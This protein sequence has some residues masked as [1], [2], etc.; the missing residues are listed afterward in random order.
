MIT[1]P[2]PDDNRIKREVV[3]PHSNLNARLHAMKALLH[4]MKAL[5]ERW[6]QEFPSLEFEIAG[7]I[8]ILTLKKAPL[9]DCSKNCPSKYSDPENGWGGVG[10]LLVAG[11]EGSH[12]YGRLRWGPETEP[13]AEQEDNFDAI[14]KEMRV[15][16]VESAKLMIR[17]LKDQREEALA[18]Y[19]HAADSVADIKMDQINR[20]FDDR[21]RELTS[22]YP[23]VLD[24][25]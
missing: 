7:E 4:A 13:P 2:D 6:G 17:I 11:H 14:D 5:C 8:S 22:K 16:G 19:R 1:I 3:I 24:G 20:R 23:E 12:E 18:P 25:D 10:C 15:A 9:A 21:V